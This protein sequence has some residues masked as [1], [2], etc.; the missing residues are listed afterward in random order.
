MDLSQNPEHRATDT[1]RMGKELISFN[2]QKTERSTQTERR[3]VGEGEVPD[4]PKTK[5]Q[6]QTEGNQQIREQITA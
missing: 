4:T 2:T 3:T 1:N 6:T 5:K